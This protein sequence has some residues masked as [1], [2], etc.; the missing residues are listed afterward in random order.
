MEDAV[1]AFVKKIL[2]LCVWGALIPLTAQ[3]MEG[4]KIRLGILNPEVEGENN[5]FHQEVIKYLKENLM[6][7]GMYEIYTQDMILQSF[8]DFKQRFPRYC[9]EPK[10]VS[11]VGSAVQMDRMIYGSV[12]KGDNTFG[13]RL[14]LIDVKSRQLIEK[15]TIEGEPGIG[16]SDIIRISVSKLHGHIDT[17]LDTAIHTYFGKKIDNRKQLYISAGSCLG[18]GILWAIMDGLNFE[19]VNSVS[20]DYTNWKN[21]SSGIGTG[22][23]LIPLF[24]RPG[25]MGNCYS[26]A[27]DDAYG[28]FF[29]P[30]GLSWSAGGEFSFGYQMRFGLKNFAAS[31]VNKATREIGFGQGILYSGDS[32]GLFSEMFFIS[33][34]SYKFNDLISFLRPFSVGGSIKLTSKK[35]GDSNISP[36]SISGNAFGAGLNLGMQIEFSEKIRYGLLLRNVPSFI[37]WNNESTGRRYFENEPVELTMGGTFQANYATF[38]ICEGYLPVYK[39][40]V[41]RFAGGV[42]RTLFRI[43]RIRLGAEKAEGLDTPWKI[44]GGF[45]LK[46]PTD[47]IWGKYCT[48]DCSYEY[49]QESP[50]S[51]VMNFSLRYGF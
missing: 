13:V 51:D 42:E 22:G 50:F 17:D 26:A 7:M 33:A 21:A 1:I 41:W 30:A 36:S 27:S 40:Q 44:N 10:C 31:F 24:G 5:T 49:N 3:E 19:K 45:G 46:F 11:A 16:L 29:N 34:L 9:R 39:D 48:L 4:V 14:S 32:E 23:D 2:F 47:Y 25:A 18:I 8:A 12:D 20:A 28:V 15:V 6:D 35:T 38:L 43:M 37:R